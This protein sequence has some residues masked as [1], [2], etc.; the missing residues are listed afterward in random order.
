M[1]KV[2]KYGF[3][4]LMR[5]KWS[6]IYFLFYLIL[7]FALLFLSSDISRAMISLMNIIIILSPLIGT[8][9][10]VM[11]FYNSKEFTQLLLAQPIKRTSIFLG[12]YLGLSISL[13]FSLFLGMFIP[14]S[15]Y[16]LFMSNEVWNF[17][18]LIFAGTML[19]FIFSALSFLI[20]LRNDDKIKGFGL[21]IL[22]WLFLAVIY[23]GLFLLA[24]VLFDDYPLEG[25]SII[26]SMLNPIDLARILILLKLDISALMSFTG[27][28]FRKFL[29]SGTGFFA[30]VSVL[31]VWMA[32]PVWMIGRVAQKRDL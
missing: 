24:L 28:V 27:A 10:G 1:R 18:T 21:A 4:D 15:I 3:F 31:L 22:L 25:F 14:F 29:G 17:L 32:V 16:G 20:A 9:F 8:M 7:T 23:D 11:Y 19:T 2:L 12:Q 30:A 13:S 5:S 26:A 6:Y